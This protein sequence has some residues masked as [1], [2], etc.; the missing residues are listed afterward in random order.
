MFASFPANSSYGPS[1]SS[2][3]GLYVTVPVAT[4]DPRGVPEPSFPPVCR[5]L[6][7]AL[8]TDGSTQDLDAS[9][10]AT[11][12]NID[13]PRIQ[14]ALNACSTTAVAAHTTLA[15]ELSTDATGTN[16]AFL[17]GPL[18]MPSNVTLLVDPNV[19]LYFS[20]NVQDYDKAAGTHTCGTINASSATASCLP[21]IDIP[22]TSQNVGIMGFGKLNGRGN[23]ALLNTF[24]TAGYAMP[25]SPTW[26]N[27]SAQAN[28]EGNQQNP[29]FIQM[30]TGSSNITLYKITILNSPLFHVSTTGAVNNFTAWDIK[31]VTPTAARNTD[32]I[33]PGNVQNV[34]IA[35]SW[36]SDGDDNVAVGAAGTTAPASNISVVNNHF[37]AG[38]GESIGSYTGAGVSNVL[39]DNNMSVGNAFAGFGSAVTANGS[40]GSG[41]IADTNSTAIRIKTA[42]DRGGLVTGIQYSNSCFLDHK[43]DIQ[44]TP[45]YSN[46][47]TTEIP[48]FN[49]ILMQN[50]VFLN[51][52][53]SSGTVELTGEF[54]SS[55]NGGG[56]VTNPLGITMDNV[57]FPSAFSSLVNS[58]APV[59]ATAD[60][61]AGNYSGG[62][63]QYTALTYGPGNVSS[64]FLT[65]YNSLIATPANN[66]TLTNNLKLSALDPPACVFT[67]LAP[68]LTGPN[69]VPQSV[70][71][72]STA[73]LDVILTPAVGGAAYP[74]GT[75]TLSDAMTG[76]TFSAALTG[77]GDTLVVPIPAA[78]LTTGVHTFSANYL[79][80]ST[81][82]VPAKYQ[83]FGSYQV[84]VVR[85]TPQI[86][87]N[88]VTSI[89]Y[90]TTLNG[91]LNASASV[92]GAF[93]FTAAPTAGSAAVVTN[94][95]V[96][97]H[98]TYTLTAT[99]A[100]TDTVNYTAATAQVT[101]QVNPATLTVTANN[102]SKAVGAINPTLTASISGFVNGDTSA[103]VSGSPALATTATASSIAGSYPI[104][105]SV[106]TLSAANYTFA[107]VNGTLTVSA[108]PTPVINTSSTLTKTTGG[109]QASVK[110]SNSGT[111]TATN[112]ILTTATLG[113]VSG[114]PLPSAAVTLAPGGST[115]L[116]INFPASAGSDGATVVEK[117]S[118]TYTGG[119]FTSSLRAQLP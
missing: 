9:V 7:A 14:A 22:Q 47:D 11:T 84:T 21:L 6:T 3:V 57:T 52:A 71:Y 100:P 33:D 4:G 88:P 98:A 114:S 107:F 41:S 48:S 106:G 29:R 55:V 80:D 43:A 61:G 110:L 117:L 99:F 45:Y 87:W 53:S 65:A 63:G 70:P 37:Y 81:Y 85:A 105:A 112:L 26:W 5:P 86:T 101:L 44:L 28:G 46:G 18:S 34:T 109:Y 17:S 69:G 97:P 62:T 13:G 54:N 19:T 59:Y 93:T 94:S 95:T 20:R 23:D 35:N 16:N 42:N 91:L 31:I 113:S 83:T 116:V 76:N 30:D 36:I 27:L 12:S 89:T 96:L 74:T 25:A 1:T 115:T 67:F 10:D 78:D 82:T 51:D 111:G 8:V 66:D 72:G 119:T 32:G 118:G 50:L 38:H 108:P 77:S 68:E 103:V 58:L 60:W 15:V 2:N 56:P 90:G 75:V 40:F 49:N 24:A 64:N 92:A 39:F 73:N 102:L 104:T 79:G